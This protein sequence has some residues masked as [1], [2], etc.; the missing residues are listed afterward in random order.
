[1]EK[2]CFLG[3][4]HRVFKYYLGELVLQSENYFQEILFKKILLHIIKF[5]Y[6]YAVLV[7]KPE[8]KETIADLDVE[9]S[10]ILKWSL[11]E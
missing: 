4:R 11:I 10:I 7:G 8:Q 2:H 5:N 3:W 9:D 6:Q 1:M